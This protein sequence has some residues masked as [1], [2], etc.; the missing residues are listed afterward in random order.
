MP[1]DTLFA[2][3]GERIENNGIT[4][5]QNEM[6]VSVDS[7]LELIEFYLK[8]MFVVFEEKDFT[9]ESG[10]CVGSGVAPAV[11]CIL[12]ATVD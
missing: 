4:P 3:T 8:S 12:L 6:G 5:F 9:Y 2:E 11:I 10:V 7:L 1:H